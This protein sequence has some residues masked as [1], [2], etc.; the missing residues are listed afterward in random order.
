[1]RLAK[2]KPLI[3]FLMGVALVGVLA[4]P[5]H[6][7]RPG[8]NLLMSLNPVGQ[9]KL[10][11]QWW[12]IY[13][14]A[15]VGI[16]LRDADRLLLAK[17]ASAEVMCQNLTTWSPQDGRESVVSQGCP[18]VVNPR[19]VQPGEDTANTRAINK[20]EVPY[21]ISPRKTKLLGNQPLT[22][23]W[24]PVET[25]ESYRVTLRGPNV[26]WSQ[27][28]SETKLVYP[29]EQPLQPEMQY[30]LTVETIQSRVSSTSEG[31]DGFSIL[32]ESETK[33]I[34]AEVERVK[35]QESNEEAQ[36]LAIARL[37]Q[38]NELYSEAIELLDTAIEN[39]ID[40][41]A[42]YQLSGEIH[43][44]VDLNQ[45]AREHYLKSLDLTDKEEDLEGFAIN[46]EGLAIT[47]AIIGKRG[48]A[49]E[50]WKNAKAAYEEL[51]DTE[52]VRDLEEKEGTI[53]GRV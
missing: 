9:V 2:F 21:L 34:L 41:A 24:N 1:M 28:T 53:L 52:K 14:A 44:Q 12:P 27:E 30:W 37:Y 46:Q 31:V 22:F 17:G 33:Q 25:A 49:V 48:E 43:R 38:S 19:L 8:L 15:K 51:G 20:P 16:P 11:R 32:P 35:Q 5:L 39:S 36:T 47:S 7:A 40:S 50:Y 45:L 3:A 18:P 42:V 13:R 23:R 6:P 29:N 26:N 4:R 10:K